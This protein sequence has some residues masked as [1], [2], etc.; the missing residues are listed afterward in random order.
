ML[1]LTWVLLL[2]LGPLAA[3]VRAQAARGTITGTVADMTGGIL[4][5]AT[6]SVRGASANNARTAVTDATGAFTFADLPPD[7]YTLTVSKADFKRLRQ[8]GLAINGGEIVRVVLRL[9]LADVILDEGVKGNPPILQ[10]ENAETGETLGRAQMERLP[11][12][13]RSL[14]DLTRL[15]PGTTHG[16]GGNNVNLSVNGQRE[17]ANSV[18][19]DGVE[20]TGN[21]NNDT[22]LRP[23]L[24]AVEELKVVTSG[25][26]PEY[27]RAAG[28]VVAM[29]MRSGTN[30]WHGSASEFA[31]PK[32]TA[33]RTFFAS[34]PSSLQQHTFG[35]VARVRPGGGVGIEF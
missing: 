28:G 5:G 35:G 27:G 26:A 3:D 22:S 1:A 10:T 24:E 29:Q 8:P 23:A 18:I 15:A 17:F 9:Q 34:E 14:L 31:R 13:G 12:L 6:V 20:V 4:I 2:G 19:V 30:W 7:I 16:Q 33:A 11:L 21:R 32:G 25:Y